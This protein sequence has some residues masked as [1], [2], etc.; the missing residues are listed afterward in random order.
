M[1]L[2]HTGTDVSM[3]A[4]PLPDPGHADKH[5]PQQRAGQSCNDTAQSAL[6]Q[7]PAELE[8]SPAR[9]SLRG[10]WPGKRDGHVQG[11]TRAA[12]LQDRLLQEG[13]VWTGKA[14]SIDPDSASQEPSP[15]AQA[16]CY[17]PPDNRPED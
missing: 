7:M 2:A 16:V 8:K 13:R 4:A 3:Y 12:P 1:T 14:E 9:T 6:R 5:L 10:D 17:E 11:H 15:E